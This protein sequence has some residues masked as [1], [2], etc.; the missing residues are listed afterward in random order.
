[1]KG[2]HTPSEK[3]L[4]KSPFVPARLVGALIGRGAL[5]LLLFHS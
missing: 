4:E 3:P 1:L 2:R 5:L